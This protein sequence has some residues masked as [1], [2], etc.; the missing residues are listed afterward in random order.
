MQPNLAPV[1][2]NVNSRLPRF[3]SN[4]VPR[5]SAMA[6]LAYDTSSPRSGI[7]GN[8]WLFPDC[9]SVSLITL[10][11]SGVLSDCVPPL[12]VCPPLWA[13]TEYRAR[14]ASS[15]PKSLREWDDGFQHTRYNVQPQV[16]S[17][18]QSFLDSIRDRIPYPDPRTRVL[19]FPSTSV[20][21]H[22][23][24]P[25]ALSIRPAR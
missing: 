19:A 23:P 6:V 9:G 15:I 13:E 1:E 14:R 18:A 7:P 11:A 8:S 2:H 20:R 24:N 21:L 10:E 12:T 22:F 5:P 4:G 17:F 16:N 3:S 25:L